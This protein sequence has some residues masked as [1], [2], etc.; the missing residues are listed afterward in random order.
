MGKLN[1]ERRTG[2]RYTVRL[3]IHYRISQRGG[4][5]RSGTG[6]TY[7]LSSNGLSFR[8][9]KPLAIGSHLEMVIEWPA[10]YGDIYPIDLQATG[11]VVRNDNGR[12]SVKVTSRKFRILT[13]M[14]ES[15][16]VSA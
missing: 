13:Q 16:P 6:T 8:A 2:N 7:E 11:F 10:R 4:L 9:R 5:E 3:P 12:T 14:A 15:L 1:V